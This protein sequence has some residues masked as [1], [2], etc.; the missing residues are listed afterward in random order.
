MELE[1][2]YPTFINHNK[3][4]NE[5]EFYIRSGDDY[6]WVVLH[7]E[8]YEK[9]LGIKNIEDK[10]ISIGNISTNWVNFGVYIEKEKIKLIS[11]YLRTLK[12]KL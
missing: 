9:R 2:N 8:E 10:K 3:K 6:F 1:F 11:L 7:K 5:S 12:N 4:E